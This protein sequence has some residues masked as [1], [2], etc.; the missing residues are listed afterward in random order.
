M[1]APE[2][3]LL[4]LSLHGAHLT[5]T[6]AVDTTDASSLAQEVHRHA[7]GILGAER[8]TIHLDEV[9]L[10]GTVTSH[11][12]AL[13]GTFLLEPAVAHNP[14]TTDDDWDQHLLHVAH[15]YTMNDLHTLTV[16]A[17]RADRSLVS[18]AHTRYSVAW[19]AIATS[20]AEAATPPDRQDLIRTGWQAIY[21]EVREMRV[22]F[23]FKDREGTHGVATAPRFV[24]YWTIPPAMPEEG[25][26][27]RLAVS[28]ILDTLTTPYRDAIVAL[29]VHD[30]YQ[31]AADALG[32]TYVAFVA[33]I[34]VARKQLRRLWF[35]PDT[36]PPA[37]GTDRRVGS[38]NKPLA[39]HCRRGHKFTPENT[40]W[41]AGRSIGRAKVRTCRACESAR[42]KKRVAARAA[43][44]QQA[45]AA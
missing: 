24:Q 39:T 42:G 5:R 35:S 12:G 8:V 40:Y 41:R 7:R 2:E 23:G 45:E 36:A 33:R 15:G 31:A 38:Y 16:A 27:E 20:L 21:R 28:Q 3:Y 44:R 19:S 6:L 32:I 1:T 4:Q 43:D 25:L 14:E 34:N 11:G 17:C 22:M 18:D 26:I 9:G 30:T 13:A 10:S 29:A 37:K